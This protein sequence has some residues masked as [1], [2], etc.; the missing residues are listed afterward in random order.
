MA[1]SQPAPAGSYMA[2][3]EKN[4][5]ATSHQGFYMWHWPP[6]EGSEP[7][8]YL[9]KEY[10]LEYGEGKYE[11]ADHFLTHER[12]TTPVTVTLKNK[13]RTQYKD[14]YVF[15]RVQQGKRSSRTNE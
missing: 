12:R 9:Q 3:A 7:F 10:W 2:F 6:E 4:K 15:C 11:W 5:K 1:S 8:Y 14:H 13:G